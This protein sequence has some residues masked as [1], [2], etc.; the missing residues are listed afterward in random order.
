M[1]RRELHPALK[2]EYKKGL[3][4]GVEKIDYPRCEGLWFVVPPP[5]PRTTPAALPVKSIARASE[6]LAK[7][8]N[9]DEAAELD[10]LV[11]YLFIRK[12][13]VESS[14]IEGT[15]STIDHVLL[16]TPDISWTLLTRRLVVLE[17]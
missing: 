12:E 1:N 8:P 13:A 3:E 11:S 10:R 14:R 5:P 16:L 2:R 17:E 6:V 9:L 4:S 15:M 7:Q